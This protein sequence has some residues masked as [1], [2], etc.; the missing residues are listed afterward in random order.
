MIA[1]ALTNGLNHKSLIYALSQIPVGSATATTSSGGSV[2]LATE[3]FNKPQGRWSA[4]AFD[5]VLAEVCLLGVH[6]TPE[7][8]E[9]FAVDLFLVD[10]GKEVKVAT[11]CA[12]ENW[13][14]TFRFEIVVKGSA[15][16]L[17]KSK[18]NYGA[19]IV[20]VYKEQ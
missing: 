18:A 17:L 12:F 6:I 1:N 16:L 4:K 5:K 8:G 3:V 11:F 2:K 14:N 15:N 20:L 13:L 10:K 9:A 7:C 19:S